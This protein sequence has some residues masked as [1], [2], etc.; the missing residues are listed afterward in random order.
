[1]LLKMRR[2]KKFWQLLFNKPSDILL[3]VMARSWF[4]ITSERYIKY[5]YYF[6]TG[7]KLNLENPR[8]FNEKL[9]W[10]KL[11]DNNPD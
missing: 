8:T 9:Q 3:W 6:K 7:E 1:M 10:L 5:W 11:Y 4:P 2:I